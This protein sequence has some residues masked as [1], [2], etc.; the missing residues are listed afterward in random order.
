MGREM[1]SEVLPISETLSRMI[2]SG[3]SKDEMSKQAIQEGFVSMFED[4][5][6]KAMAGETTLD[7]VYRVAR[8]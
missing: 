2:A 8:L 3:A 4:G 6:N 5:I 1:I 7:E